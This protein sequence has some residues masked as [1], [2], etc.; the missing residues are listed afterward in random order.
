ME[1]R[2]RV[3]FYSMVLLL[4]VILVPSLGS[5]TKSIKVGAVVGLTGRFSGYAVKWGPGWRTAVEDINNAG[6]IKSLGGAKIELI[7]ADNKSDSSVA[8]KETERLITVEKVDFILGP[9]VSHV[10]LAI[11]PVCERYKIPLLQNGAGADVVFEKGAKYFF[12]CGVP[13]ESTAAKNG[14]DLFEYLVKEHNV[15]ADRIVL[16]SNSTSMGRC[17]TKLMKEMAD[18]AGYNVVDYIEY[19]PKAKDFVPLVTKLKMLKPDVLMGSGHGGDGALLQKAFHVEKFRPLIIGGGSA[20]GSAQFPTI[21]PPEVMAE[22]VDGQ[23]AM[24]VSPDD[25]RHVRPLV[26]RLLSRLETKH[27][28]QPVW[29]YPMIGYQPIYLMAKVLEACGSTDPDI[30]MKATRDLK[31]PA[32]ELLLPA[33]G[34]VTWDETG[35]PNGEFWG[36][37]QWQDGVHRCVWP[38]SLATSKPKLRKAWFR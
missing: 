24:I 29:Y 2:L 32:E 35:R 33:E 20:Y 1:K 27:G 16:I 26:E 4:S 28:K 36:V 25:L 11:Q 38:K 22:T 7:E 12:G 31:M 8:A 5:A 34:I 23:F 10:T 3:M 18:K 6:G 21:L 14:F 19:N 15:K 30:F 37:V 13:P 9:M 17:H